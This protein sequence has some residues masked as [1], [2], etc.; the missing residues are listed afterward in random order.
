MNYLPLVSEA[1]ARAIDDAF[2]G[3]AAFARVVA[4]V[5]RQSTAEG[6]NSRPQSW[7]GHIRSV[8]SSALLRRSQRAGTFERGHSRT[9]HARIGAISDRPATGRKVSVP[10]I[11]VQAG[12]CLQSKRDVNSRPIVYKPF[13][14]WPI[15]DA[16]FAKTIDSVHMS[17]PNDGRC[18]VLPDQC[19]SKSRLLLMRS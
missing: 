12:N 8:L 16:F 14:G 4:A 19:E 18:Q 6:R 3:A 7:G 5:G 10:L 13:T 17:A 9:C 15:A 11:M 1:W 2:G